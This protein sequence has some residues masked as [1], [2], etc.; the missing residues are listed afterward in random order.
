M[1]SSI[2]LTF[3]STRY[4]AFISGLAHI[5]F[6]T[7]NQSAVIHGG[8]YGLILAADTAAVSRHGHITDYPSDRETVGLQIPTAD[9]K[10]PN[11]RILHAG[12]CVHCEQN[13]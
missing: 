5:T 2:D 6:P 4:V 10:V 11:H 1:F 12:P 9:G 8:E 7:S 3:L 13:L